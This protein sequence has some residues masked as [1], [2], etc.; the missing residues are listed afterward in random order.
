MR[1]A[2]LNRQYWGSRS[3]QEAAS[4]FQNLKFPSFDVDFDHSDSGN[5]TRRNELVQGA[6]LYSH[7]LNLGFHWWDKGSVS[8]VDQV[9]IERG[10]TACGSHRQ[11][12]GTHIFGSVQFQ[13]LEELAIQFGFRLE[14]KDGASGSDQSRGKNRHD[15]DVC[16]HIH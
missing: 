8:F 4:S 11:W 14:R 10:L 16:P 7:P 2:A 6:H 12:E 1:T 5:V 13:V 3:A 15:S 9:E